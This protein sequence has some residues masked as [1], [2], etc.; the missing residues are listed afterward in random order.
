MLR[1]FLIIVVIGTIVTN[2]FILEEAM[3]GREVLFRLLNIAGDP[4]DINSWDGL[5]LRLFLLLFRMGLRF[6]LLVHEFA[7][8]NR[9]LFLRQ[10]SIRFARRVVSKLVGEGLVVIVSDQLKLNVPWTDIITI[11][12]YLSFFGLLLRFK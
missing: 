1:L 2:N 4:A 9:R 12:R 10:A 3:E 8:L 5:G 7:D 11:L 6:G